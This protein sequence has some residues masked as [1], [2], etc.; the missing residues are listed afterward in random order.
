VV[1]SGYAVWENT[2][3][4]GK[5]APV[6]VANLRTGRVRVI[7]GR[8]V[9]IPFIDGRMVVWTARDRQRM[10]LTLRAASLATGQPAPLPPV[11]RDFMK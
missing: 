7:H 6:S 10:R 2:Y 4:K 8:T 3:G 9:G 5:P 1:G 11:L